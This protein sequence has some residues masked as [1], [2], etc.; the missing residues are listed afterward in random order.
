MLLINKWQGGGVPCRDYQGRRPGEAIVWAK[1][2]A[3]LANRTRAYV[4]SALHST[5]TA[6]LSND[7]RHPALELPP[8]LRRQKT[9]EALT[10]ALLERVAAAVQS[11]AAQIP[12]GM[13]RSEAFGET[14]SDP[15]FPKYS[16][17]HAKIQC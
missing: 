1:E 14:T 13:S 9:L 8:A 15:P 2:V 4:T 6:S 16:G 11:Q 10:A 5:P 7:G 17:C 12:G 3:A